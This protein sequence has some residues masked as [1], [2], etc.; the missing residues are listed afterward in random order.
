M[1]KTT[2]AFI[3]LLTILMVTITSPSKS[4]ILI[5][6]IPLDYS[7]LSFSVLPSSPCRIENK[8]NEPLEWI[9]EE[10]NITIQAHSE[11]IWIA[12]KAVG[13]YQ[14]RINSSGKTLQANFFIMKSLE[15]IKEQD[16]HFT[17]GDYPKTKYKNLDQYGIPKGMIQVT[18]KN[19]DT[20]ISPHFT[21]GQFLT[22]QGGQFPKYVIISS[23]LLYK[24][25]LIIQEME[26]DGF[27]IENMHVMS[28]YRTPYYNAKIGN[29]KY[30]RH[31]YGD[32]AD[33][34]L[35]N[36]RNK[37]M[38]DLNKD[39]KINFEDAKLMAKY[40][41]KIDNDPRYQWLIGGLAA[42]KSSGAHRGF[43]HV[44]TRGFKA[45]W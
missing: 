27:I 36:D 9:F 18:E 26:E 14:I 15:D 29:G 43:I 45:R 19:K 8:G 31:V 6:E 4:Q 22:K 41:R 7:L 21:L 20:P 12:P 17:L 10:K 33:I 38:D 23:K 37:A 39:Q 44:D 24:L 13:T 40:V 25:E 35:D 42:Y 5:N 34:Y 30:S 11:F 2:K 16:K 32:A 1:E 3:I 28:G